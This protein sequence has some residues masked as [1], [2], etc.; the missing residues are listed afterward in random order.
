MSQNEQDS[1]PVILITGPTASGK[2]RLA[3]S[4]AERLGG[5]IIN[6]D[7]MQ[8]YRELAILTAR[9][10]PRDLELVPHRLYG[11]LA[12]AD[13]CSAGRW[14][15]LAIE[16]IEAARRQAQPALVVGGTG[17]YLQALEQGIAEIPDVPP[18][19]REAA[20]ARHA[21]LGGLAFHAELALRDPESAARLHPS[22]GQ[23]LIRAWE[24]VE[25]TGRSLAD[26]Q[27]RAGPRVPYRFLRLVLLPPRA[28]LYADCD[29]RFL[30]ML[31]AGA[32]DE[33]EAL[34]ARNLDPRL[35]VMKAVG[36]AELA[37]YL[38]GETDLETATGRAQQAT[39]RYAK[40]Q[41]TW[42]RGHAAGAVVIDAQY[43]ESLEAEIFA[44][45]CSFMLTA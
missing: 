38:R 17:L 25:A 2:S 40:R 42:Q 36:V 8:V 26:W 14:R 31:D 29:R 27:S 3:L 16:E 45:I 4:L 43:S 34:L 1:T 33:V 19:I 28:P 18:A 15:R 22:D 11:V 30:R 24:V 44:K 20:R 13:V 23:R 5:I 37:A 12:G 9:P 21:L 32:V 35:P 10:T 7:S 41:Y 39:R 6:A